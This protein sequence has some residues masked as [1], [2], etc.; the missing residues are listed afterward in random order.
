VKLGIRIP[1][2]WFGTPVDGIPR[3]WEHFKIDGLMPN[4][5]DIIRSCRPRE[6]VM[7]DGIHSY[8]H[9]KGSVMMD[10][11]GFLFMK[12]K[13]I[14]ISAYDVLDLYECS[15]PD[16]GVVLDHPLVPNLPSH[17]K[18]RRQ[19]RTL[20]NTKVMVA[21]KKLSSPVI[22]PVIHGYSS[23]SIR[24]YVRELNKMGEFPIYGIGSLVPS[25]FN[26]RGNGGIFDVIETICEAKKQLPSDSKIHVFGIGSTLTM[27]MM[28][29]AGVDCVD[30]SSWRWKAAYGA[31]QLPGTG[32][33]YITGKAGKKSDKKYLNLSRNEKRLLDACKCPA[34]KEHSLS[35]LRKS[36]S[37]RALHNAW[38]F[39]KEVQK[40]R[41]LIRSSEYSQYVN[42][43][44][45]RT[46]FWRVLE[47]ISKVRASFER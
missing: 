1:S 26:T 34:C 17:I 14:T 29:Y 5:Y 38:V 7:T 21:N 37:L 45:D 43:I 33:R 25:V 39:Q 3:P 36:F 30:S 8:L 19:L 2:L 6:P 41:R 46:R 32:D 16:F 22:V 10:S 23:D 35:E 40:A 9:F 42:Q 12:R 18:R 13:R 27:H 28:F 20:H 11:G 31:I 24:W 47:H 44:I 4:A 15:K